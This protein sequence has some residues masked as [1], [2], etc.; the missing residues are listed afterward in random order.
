MVYKNMI[1]QV[2]EYGGVLLPAASAEN[3]K[4][5]QVLQNRGLRC[6]LNKDQYTHVINLH[7]EANLLK[8]KYR[9]EQHQLNLMFDRSQEKRT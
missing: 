3:R 6:A 2:I 4:K 7:P 1:L 9:R 5:L 8:L